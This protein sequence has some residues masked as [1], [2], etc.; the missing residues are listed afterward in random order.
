M[1][2]AVIILLLIL[3]FR[4]FAQNPDDLK[5]FEH[6]FA[7]KSQN[8]KWGDQLR[9]SKN[10]LTFIFSTAFVLYKKVLSSQD[11]DACVFTPSCSVYAVESIKQEGIVKGYFNAIDRITRCNPVPKKD[12]PVDLSTGKYFDPVESSSPGQN[13]L[14]ASEIQIMPV[15]K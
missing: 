8:N 2:A 6:L 9:D 12:M 14:K 7:G 15:N 5:K 13:D 1:K 11:I 10:E 3:P 4:C